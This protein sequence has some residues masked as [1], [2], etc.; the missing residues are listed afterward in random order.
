[1]V[2]MNGILIQTAYSQNDSGSSDTEISD[3]ERYY[4][5][6]INLYKEG[7][8][9]EA[10]DEFNRILALDASFRDAA[11]FKAKCETQ[12]EL[13]ATGATPT[14]KTEF[15]IVD[16]SLVGP[17][18][19]TIQ[20]NPEE[21]KIQRVRELVEAGEQY[22]EYALYKEALDK[23]EQAI[24][25]APDNERARK[26]S[27]A[28][29]IGLFQKQRTDMEDKGKQQ[30]E[31]LRR[32]IEQMKQLPDGADPTGIKSLSI[33]INQIDER[34]PEELTRSRIEETLSNP[35]GVVFEDIHLLDILDFITDNYDI[36]IMVDNRVIQGPA[37]DVSLGGPGG[38]GAPPAQPQTAQIN[39]G[40]Q[41]AQQG[42]PGQQGQG[43]GQDFIV[44]DGMITY[45]NL[46]EVTLREALK[47]ILR[48]LNLDYSIQSSFIWISTHENIRTE[49]FED[50][51]TRYYELKNAGA[52][53][54]FKL[55][56]S[57]QGGRQFNQGG[58][59]GGQGGGGQG[60]GAGGQG[61]QGGAGQFSNIQE[62]FEGGDFDDASV[63]EFP[64]PFSQQQ[65]TGGVGGQGGQQGGVG[66]QGAQEIGP[67]LGA[68]AG[69]AGEPRVMFILRTLVPGVLEPV[70]GRQLSFMFY[71]IINNQLVVHNTPANHDIL[72]K[73]IEHL[74]ATPK[75]VA[76][77][78]KFITIA[79]GDLDKKGFSWNGAVS[80]IN[81]R[82]IPGQ[83]TQ[84]VDLNGDGI[85][86]EIPANIGLD[87]NPIINNKVL[88]QGIA[89]ALISPG[90]PGD[91]SLG[92]TILDTADG[93]FLD[94]TFEYLN[95]LSETELLSAPRV[96]TMNQKPAVIADL[97]TETFVTG[98]Q[99]EVDQNAGTA[100]GDSSEI[101]N[102]TRTV[103]TEGFIFGISLSVTP[104]IADN[105]VRLWLN[106]QVI[107]KIGVKT[108]PLSNFI[109]GVEVNDFIEIP[110]TSVQAV[111]TN[112]IVLD[113]ETVVLGGMIRDSTLKQTS[114][115]PYLSNIPIL[116]NLFRG[117]SSEITQQSLLIFVTPT[118]IDRSG[119]RYFQSEF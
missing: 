63:G 9:R 11:S 96:T 83:G 115:F 68:A 42:G 27:N 19:E 94:M 81:E 5:A 67:G 25:I 79:V 117:T 113:G 93:D 91:V 34:V 51:E 98:S 69:F 58:G 116:G 99:T 50:L 12:L 24:L 45:V 86:E 37:D 57:S 26:G 78:A 100:G 3:V 39:F 59:G 35:V 6:G 85:L 16:P 80:D 17:E 10:L 90:P 23:F 107:N 8:Y 105:Q 87:G 40:S 95:S 103:F 97:T 114:K 15:E 112:V 46:K 101:L 55:V 47:A 75:M 22:L 2:G 44:T 64:N 108:I 33:P 48:P 14:S 54:L 102:I 61:G 49:S 52:E 21:F 111:W 77:E 66:Q 18:G 88:S 70:T 104:Q 31:L 36:N 4:R 76:I 38:I 92:F 56:I 89:D 73:N 41:Q 62:L 71:N 84:L 53:T 74:D 13:A 1:M 30:A 110:N 7:N 72:V 82:L 118:I 28:A 65:G 32:H 60:G 43:Q 106:P 29:S 20:L 109:D 119:S